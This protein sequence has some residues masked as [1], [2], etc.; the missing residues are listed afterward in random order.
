MDGPRPRSRHFGD[1]PPQ[2]N[3]PDWDLSNGT[4]RSE[5]TDAMPPGDGASKG[6]KLSLGASCFEDGHGNEERL[7]V[8]S[9]HLWGE[10]AWFGPLQP[11]EAGP[12]GPKSWTPT[13]PRWVRSVVI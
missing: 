9:G 2:G 4:L 11:E 5:I 1:A 3:A 8:F 10:R 13:L 7:M 6:A 12:A